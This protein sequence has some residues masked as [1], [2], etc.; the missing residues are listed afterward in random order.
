MPFT[1]CVATECCTDILSNTAQVLTSL[2]EALQADRSSSVGKDN[3]YRLLEEAIELFQ[4]CLTLQEYQFSESQAQ[5]DAMTTS[6]SDEIP[7]TED[8]GVSI[9]EDT[10]T[11]PSEAQDE[12]WASI[13]EPVTNDTLLE[14][15]LAQLE[16]LTDLCSYI[17]GDEGRGLAW[18]EEYATGL[19]TQKLPTY[20]QGTDREEEA[21]LTRA[22]FLAA[23]AE[24]N[25]QS[26][27]I[28]AA[29]Y[30]RGLEEAYGKLD[31]SSDPEGLCEKAEALIAY[32]SALRTQQ[33]GSDPNNPNQKAATTSRW[34]ALS[35]ALDSLTAA[36]KLPSA[37]NLAKI[38]L[39]RGDCELLRFQLGLTPT[40]Y[41]AAAKNA[42]TLLK[43]AGTFYRGAEAHAVAAKGDKEVKEAVVKQA[44][45]GAL[46]GEGEK[47]MELV[48]VE[49]EAA[50]VVLEEAVDDGLITI[51]WLVKAGIMH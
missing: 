1:C 15:V 25:F 11:Q 46:A 41:P 5:Q 44:L 19:L 36:S 47:L 23:L 26:H 4:R 27:Q 33:D 16:T 18:I 37:D 2:V 40:L 21:A 29:T 50:Q 13:V 20:V 6:D 8:G 34:S 51:D 12:R 24:A 31:L 3:A 43:N 9:S 22:N 17:T 35:T 45:V 28:D 49:T 48:K 7:D 14:T 42:P 39:S 10:D 32:N 38:H 30:Q